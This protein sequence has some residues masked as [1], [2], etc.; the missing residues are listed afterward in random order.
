MAQ[1]H[2]SQNHFCNEDYIKRIIDKELGKY[3]SGTLMFLPFFVIP[4]SLKIKFRTISR[5]WFTSNADS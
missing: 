2:V 5:I 3:V 4:S 1:F